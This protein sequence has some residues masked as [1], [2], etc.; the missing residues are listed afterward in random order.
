MDSVE[1]MKVYYCFSAVGIDG[2]FNILINGIFNDSEISA[3]AAT[4][5]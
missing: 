5:E 2:L 4:P 1:R 3:I